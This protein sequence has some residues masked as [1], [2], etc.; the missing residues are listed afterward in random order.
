MAD[1]QARIA[2]LLRRAGFGAS[3]E[4]LAYFV[5]Q[6]FDRTL[7]WLVN[8]PEGPD[9]LDSYIGQ[10]GYVAVT[11]RG[12][13]SPNSVITDARQRWLFRM[14][15]SL[16]PLQE[17][18]ALFWHNHFATAYTKIAGLYGGQ[19]ATRTMA[20]KP[21]ED[22]A[23]MKGQ[24]ELLREYALGNFRD[25]LEAISKDA[26]MLIWLDGR[27]NVRAYPQ[28]NYAREL[29]ELFTFGVGFYTEQ[30]VY[31][32]A[33]AFTGWNL[34]RTGDRTNPLASKLEFFYNAGQ[35]DTASKT[36]SF[37]IY[38]DG[39][40][41]IPARSAASGMQDGIDLINAV[42]RHPETGPRLAR[43]LYGY[44]VSE[45]NPPSQAFIDYVSGIYY[46]SN[47]D[48]RQVVGAVLRS[49]EFSD[50]A[51]YFSRYAWPVEYVVRLI[52]EVGWA[53]FSVDGALAP[54]TA[55]GQLLLE[56]PDVNGWELGKGWMTAGAMIARMNFASTLSANQRINLLNVAR[57]YRASPETLASYFLDRMQ[58][59]PL[60]EPV[61]NELLNYLRAGGNWS[62]SDSQLTTKTA[63][64]VHLVASL[65]EYQ[66]N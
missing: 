48:M 61:Y 49:Q 21:S 41:T 29:M 64:L 28:E 25:F 13:F 58:T 60:D 44:F 14:V 27:T 1:D 40:R 7:D 16:R 38:P 17:K 35:H 19:E 32:G 59:A 12:T 6:G 54:L 37:P 31:A 33:R 4:E 5:D 10:P 23:Q 39:G 56:P 15:H 47:Y 46:S 55:M 52:K 3:P 42:A 36:F 2:H 66:F 45:T 51:N 50:P 24:L 57:P 43:K 30:D 22:L 8:Y 63:G 53:G 11:T 26:A 9:K 18:M 20:A 34:A 65:S 62:G